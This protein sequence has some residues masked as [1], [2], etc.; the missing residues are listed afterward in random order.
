VRLLI[1]HAALARGLATVARSIPSRTPMPVLTGVL[2]NASSEDVTLVAT[3]L[4]LGIRCRIAADVAEPGAM[5][6]PAHYLTEMVR[7]IP[8]GEISWQ[9]EPD[10]AISQLRWQRSEFTIHGFA[11]DQY[12]SFPVFPKEGVTFQRQ[13]LRDALRNTVFAASAD[14][15]RPALAGVE[16]VLADGDMRALATDG[17][18]V[19]LHRSNPGRTSW[20]QGQRLLVPA[21][22]L[23][24]VA[25]CLEGEGEGRLAV[26]E[27]QLLL[28][29][30]DTQIAVRLLEGRY[31]A[32]LDLLPK[33]YPTTVLVARDAFYAAC[34][35]VS[36]VADSPERLHAV[37]MSVAGDRLSL[38]ARSPE[39]GEASEVVS[40][41]VTGPELTVGF[42]AR[43]LLEGLRHMEGDEVLL[44]LSGPLS[45]ARLRR[46]GDEGF[47]Y[48]L[49]PV[50]IG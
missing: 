49:M 4:E 33:E 8:G 16:L 32:V 26:Q 12:P 15:A 5:V 10:R 38:A 18:R 2:V 34:E 24:E 9:A 28:D 45:A 36:L 31:P 39:V 25:R 19:A 22:A 27:S 43:L 21:R 11:A 47:L 14:A 46:P 3:D 20:E 50:R 48:M 44:E 42:N 13:L 41:E 17:M 29:L 7:R 1:D 35:R 30:G 37:T 6:L 23:Q 40:A